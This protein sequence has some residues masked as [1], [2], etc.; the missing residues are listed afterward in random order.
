[1]IQF[2][3]KNYPYPVLAPGRDD[4]SDC[5]FEVCFCEEDI[6]VTEDNIEIPI[7]YKLYCETLERMI[8]N[9][10]AQVVIKI[11]SSPASYS[12]IIRFDEN[13]KEQIFKIPKYHVIGNIE[14]T[15]IIVAKEKID[16]FSCCEFNQLYFSGMTFDFQ[17]GDFL[18]LDTTRKIYID[19]SELE[20]PIASIFT[21]NKVVEQEEDI[22]IDFSDE[23][24]N[25]NLSVELNKMYWTLKDFNNGAL[26]RYVIAVIVYPALVEA[27]EQIKDHYREDDD[28]DYS[29]KRWFRAIELKAQ[30]HDVVMAEYNGS[31][32]ALAD[33][34]LG[35]IALDALQSFKETLDQEMNNGE[36][37]MIGGVD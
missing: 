3:K 17:K 32:V 20:K 26:R 30:K 33:A 18:A 5:F 15:G 21:I 36:M 22:V 27:I 34:L 29:E 4:Y 11:K 35:N 25:I 19:D 9:S 24:I 8:S 13:K 37:Q 31:S 12:R 2:N 10:K 16:H 14:L 28:E 1:M 23:K 7:S 6:V